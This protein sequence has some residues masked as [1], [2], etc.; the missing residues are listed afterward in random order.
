MV[1]FRLERLGR[2]GGNRAV[3]SSLPAAAYGCRIIGWGI[4]PGGIPNPATDTGGGGAA[5]GSLLMA[6]RAGLAITGAPTMEDMTGAPSGMG[7]E[8]ATW[9]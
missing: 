1:V 9:K 6:A 2:Q 5:T 3:V 4:P 8:A 7:G